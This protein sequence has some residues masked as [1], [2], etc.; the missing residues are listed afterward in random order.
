MSRHVVVIG[1]VHPSVLVGAGEDPS[2]PP[3]PTSWLDSVKPAWL[4]VSHPASTA[5]EIQR[6]AA[7]NGLSQVAGAAIGAAIGHYVAKR[8]YAG[9]A[10][11]AVA[12]QVAAQLVPGVAGLGPVAP[13]I[14]NAVIAG[15]GAGVAYLI[16]KKPI[17]G[18]VVAVGL[19]QGTGALW[20]GI[21]YTATRGPST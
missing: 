6:T 9:A 10:A 13:V 1:R 2:T 5:A 17:D 12:G 7:V 21:V 19:N 11:G 14:G 3:A 8:P 15:I 20:N 4:G 18:A 16:G